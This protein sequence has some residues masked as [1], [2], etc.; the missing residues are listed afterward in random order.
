MRTGFDYRK[1]LQ[2]LLPKGNIWNRREDSVLGE[3]LLAEGD[4]LA[5]V[6]N[7]SLDLLAERF[8]RNAVYMNSE[9]EFD[10]GLPNDCYSYVDTTLEE[11]KNI[12][13]AK[14]ISTARLDKQY[15]IDYAGDLGYEITIDEFTPLWSGLARSG[16]L[17][18]SQRGIFYWRVNI[19]N[20]D[21][22]WIFLRSGLGSS[23]DP[24]AK[25]PGTELLTCILNKVK[26]AHTVLIYRLVG[27]AFDSGFSTGFDALQVDQSNLYGGFDV[28]FSNGFT[29]GHGG[30][31]SDGFDSGFSRQT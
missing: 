5:R 27:P 25:I 24:L 17:C 18:I 15:Y 6:E 23:G 26:P 10:L 21:T 22:E 7:H 1:L 31:F 29:V 16:D 30:G 3:V 2:S 8:P 4:E 19:Y 11:R 12:S 28:G 20:A 14:Y 9:H 13:Q